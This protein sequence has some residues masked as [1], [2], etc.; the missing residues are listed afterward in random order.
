MMNEDTELDNS[1][2]QGDDTYLKVL[3]KPCS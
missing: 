1:I 3:L 2:I